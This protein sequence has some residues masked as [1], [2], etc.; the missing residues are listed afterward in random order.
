V[1]ADAHDFEVEVEVEVEV[2]FEVEFKNR[3]QTPKCLIQ[4]SAISCRLQIQTLSCDST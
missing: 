1:W 3:N 2:E 4:W